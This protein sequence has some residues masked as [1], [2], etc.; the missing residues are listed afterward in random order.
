[1]QII[2]PFLISEILHFIETPKGEDGGLNYGISLVIIYVIVDIIM[3][4]VWTQGEFIQA[5]WA[6]KCSHGVIGLI[7]EKLLKIS[8]ATNK[9]FSQGEIINFIEIDSS[10]INQVAIQFP[11]VSRFPIQLI[12]AL[13]FL[14]YIFGVAFLISIVVAIIIFASN[15]FITKINAKYQ[16]KLMKTKD[17]R[18]RYTTETVNNIK[19]IK[20]NSWKD[21]VLKRILKVRNDELFIYKIQTILKTMSDFVSWIV[22]PALIIS[23]FFTFFMLGNTISIGK[24]FAAI[25]VFAYLE[26]PL[27]WYPQFIKSLIEFNISMKRIQKFLNWNETNENLSWLNYEKT[28]GRQ[29][30]N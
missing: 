29:I 17:E 22:S 4:I 14:F 24:A 23:T 9:D 8:A 30:K 2:Q 10:K 16:E 18:M 7:Y 11:M 1:M 12:F 5:V 26:H 15:F 27:R 6:I 20:F 25:Q 19:E 3:K 28:R 13:I 21:L